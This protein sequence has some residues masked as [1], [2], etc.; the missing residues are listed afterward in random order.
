MESNGMST[1]FAN[2]KCNIKDGKG[3][4]CAQATK[5]GGM[6]VLDTVSGGVQGGTACTADVSISLW[7]AR[8]GHA[9]MRGIA[10]TVKAKAVDGLACT[11]LG[12][13]TVCESC[14]YGRAHR[15][16]FPKK[17]TSRAIGVLDLVHSD[18]YGPMPVE[19]VG[20]ARYY[21]GFTDD[22]SRWSDVFCTKRKSDVLECFIRWQGR[23]ERQTGRKIRVLRSDNGGE[24]MSMEFSKHLEQSGIRHELSVPYNPQQNGVAERLN[25]TLLNSVRTMLK[26]VDCEKKWWAEA[27]TTA[28]YV[29]NR[30]TTVGLPSNTTP[31]EVWFG[32]RPNVS[33]LRVFG[34]KCWYVTP[35]AQRDKLDD[36]SRE[37]MMLGYSATQKGYKIWD[38]SLNRV[39]ISRDVTFLEELAAS[40]TTPTTKE[41]WLNVPDIGARSG[42]DDD[43]PGS[44]HSNDGDTLSGGTSEDILEDIS[45][46]GEAADEGEF[47]TATDSDTNEHPRRSGRSRRP[48]GGWWATCALIAN[49]TDPTTVSQALGRPDA[50]HWRESMESEYDSLHRHKSWTLVP[51][52]ADRKVIPCK[53]VFKQKV[54]KSDTGA[55]AVKYKSSLVA[56]G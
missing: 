19:S 46:S 33:H 28:C 6:Y 10:N 48:P 5:K 18:V 20:G 40:N 50:A 55:D 21:V 56:K 3:R 27:V 15:L 29:K 49:T 13:D 9:N 26:H 32:T 37:G 16:P 11:G 53:W 36:R 14:V 51:K 54:I 23:V 30:V 25:R 41:D 42:G 12:T 38:E 34:A 17:S 47:E 44:E 22:C 7:H 2:G 39:V 35:K 31:Y 52:P 43:L 45:G 8:L 24:Y 1:N 4:I